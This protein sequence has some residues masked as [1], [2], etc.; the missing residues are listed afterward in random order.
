VRVEDAGRPHIDP[1]EV[2]IV[3]DT[4][5]VLV[6]ERVV[7]MAVGA[8][9]DLAG[10]GDVEALAPDQIVI[11]PVAVA[12]QSGIVGELRPARAIPAADAPVLGEP[13]PP[14]VAV[15]VAELVTGAMRP[16]FAGREVFRGTRE[17][18]APEWPIA[19]VLGESR[20]TTIGSKPSK[21]IDTDT[22]LATGNAWTRSS[23]TLT[24]LVSPAGIWLRFMGSSAIALKLAAGTVISGGSLPP[25]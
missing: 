2:A 20:L 13:L 14:L 4:S 15:V 11:V 5:H 19:D 10:G 6:R 3:P 22:E 9:D 7:G 16:V 8:R 25:E 1:H 17:R 24:R 12:E 18:E 21:V 23:G